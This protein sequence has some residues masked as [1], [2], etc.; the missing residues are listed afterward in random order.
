MIGLRYGPPVFPNDDL[1]D[2]QA[3]TLDEFRRQKMN[4]FHIV[5]FSEGTR[6]VIYS[7]RYFT[8]DW[9]R[10]VESGGWGP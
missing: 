9:V 1:V 6:F 2:S 10:S 4:A 3:V 8:V 5:D 7:Y